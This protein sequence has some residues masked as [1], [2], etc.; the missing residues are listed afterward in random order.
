MARELRSGCQALG[1]SMIDASFTPR[2][3]AASG[4]IAIFSRTVPDRA[5][6]KS[7]VVCLHDA[8]TRNLQFW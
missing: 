4:V 8:A 3:G 2:R 5:Y 1:T 7:C 6:S